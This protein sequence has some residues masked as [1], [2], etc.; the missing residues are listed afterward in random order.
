[1]VETNERIIQ[2]YG[3]A[4]LNIMSQELMSKPRD[5]MLQI[6]VFLAVS[7][8]DA[9]LAQTEKILFAKPSVTRKVVVWSENQKKESKT[10]CW[11]IYTYVN[12]NLRS[13]SDLCNYYFPLSVEAGAAN[14]G[15]I[16]PCDCSRALIVY[17]THR[18][19]KEHGIKEQS[20]VYN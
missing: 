16:W 10:K 17:C 6:C 8:D 1:M 9:Y 12:L 18:E 14:M 2:Q 19:Y 15:A 7:C 3:D 13:N 4:V 11:N 5:T 20:H